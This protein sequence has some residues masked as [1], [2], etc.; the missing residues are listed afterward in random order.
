MS[1]FRKLAKH[2]LMCVLVEVRFST[3]LNLETYIPKIQD[4]LRK[5][6]PLFV[7]DSEQNIN[8]TPSGIDIQNSNKW[9]FSSKDKT[10]SLQVTPERLVFLTKKY[11]R[12]DDF[13]NRTHRLVA[14]IEDVVSPSLYSRLGLRYCDCIKTP[15]D[16][17]SDDDLRR[18]FNTESYFFPPALTKLGASHSQRTES[19][20]KTDH[21]ILVVRSLL[22]FSNLTVLDELGRQNYVELKT[23]DK[24]SVRVILDFDHFWQDEENQKDFNANEIVS[25]LHNLHETSRQ[26]FWD[27]TSDYAK[28]TIWS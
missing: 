23:D 14:A 7:T 25:Q 15:N 28:E 4:L 11:D 17:N 1:T 5:D 19:A 18:L 8:V 21:G 22:N 6:Y 26:A 20:L 16:T 24:P 13:A 12:F 27:L 9:I 2:P 3:V 10:C